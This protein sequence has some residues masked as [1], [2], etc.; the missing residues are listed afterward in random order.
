[1]YGHNPWTEDPDYDEDLEY[2]DRG[3]A[4]FHE[5]QDRELE[6]SHEDPRQ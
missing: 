5:R 6:R 1:M 3:D 2:D 4:L